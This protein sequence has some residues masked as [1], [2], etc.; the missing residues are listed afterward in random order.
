MDNLI[1][2]SDAGVNAELKGC[3]QPAAKLFELWTNPVD[4]T[5]NYPQVSYAQGFTPTAPLPLVRVFHR[6]YLAF[7]ITQ[8]TP[9]RGTRQSARTRCG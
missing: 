7:K 9:G 6:A 4:N 2:V 3:P 1:W 8:T 5:A